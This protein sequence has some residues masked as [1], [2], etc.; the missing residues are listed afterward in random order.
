[1]GNVTTT[2]IRTLEPGTEYVFSIAA[3][4][5]GAYNER[6]ASKPTDLYGR[7]N[8]FSGFL[9]NFSPYTNITATLL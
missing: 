5:E 1:V 4:S 9:S 8:H 3:I 7:R 6:S 2:S